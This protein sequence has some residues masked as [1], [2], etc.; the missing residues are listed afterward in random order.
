MN[1]IKF[2]SLFI[3]LISIDFQ[4]VAQKISNIYFEKLP[5]D[6]QLYPRNTQNVSDIEIKGF[7]DQKKQKN[8]LQTKKEKPQT[9]LKKKLKTRCPI[10]ELKNLLK[11]W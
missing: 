5:Q 2:V 1:L 9:Q 11:H 8:K 3:F 6:L 10:E 4:L 7:A